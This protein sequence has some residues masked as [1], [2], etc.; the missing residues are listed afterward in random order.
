MHLN[1]TQLAGPASWDIYERAKRL[2]AVR[3]DEC[4]VVGY[5]VIK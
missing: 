3:L 2:L 5:S 4:V 1:C